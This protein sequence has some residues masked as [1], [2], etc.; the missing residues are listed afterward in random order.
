MAEPKIEKIVEG[1]VRLLE[2]ILP[3]N[4][5]LYFPLLSATF[6]WIVRK[7]REWKKKILEWQV[8]PD[9][10]IVKTKSNDFILNFYLSHSELRD[11]YQ[12]T[13]NKKDYRK[14]RKDFSSL[15]P[16]YG[17]EDP[18]VTALFSD[19][20]KLG[21]IKK[22]AA[23]FDIRV[24]SAKK[25]IRQVKNTGHLLS[26][27]EGFVSGISSLGSEF[28]TQ[29]RSRQALENIIKKLIREKNE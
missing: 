6:T 21:N 12:S 25:E 10:D 15:Y 9:P 29:S 18:F 27:L 16:L 19:E 23:E 13:L 24:N 1:A 2:E 26:A 5:T 20:L 3:E 17:L 8:W 4:T 14:L 22:I 28:L 11:C 7:E